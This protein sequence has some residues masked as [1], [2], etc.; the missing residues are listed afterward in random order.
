MRIKGDEG[1]NKL[2]N[3]LDKLIEIYSTD[4]KN[5]KEKMVNGIKIPFFIYT[6]KI[7]QNFQQ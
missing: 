5:H 1:E 7:L 2:I 3:K 4:I 6:A